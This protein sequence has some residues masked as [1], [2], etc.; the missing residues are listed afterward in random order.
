MAFLKYQ[1]AASF[2]SRE[3]YSLFESDPIK[4][5]VY[6]LFNS[7][8]DLA[9][10]TH[11]VS[12]WTLETCLHSLWGEES[13]GG[14]PFKTSSSR[15]TA[16]SLDFEEF[17]LKLWHFC[18]FLHVAMSFLLPPLM[19]EDGA[20]LL[21]HTHFLVAFGNFPGPTVYSTEVFSINL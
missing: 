3:Q 4:C 1:P 12:W 6:L 11:T 21:W 5:F 2:L 10:F 13:C 18:G 8:V 19:R 7:R 9:V 15:C 16:A 20:A 17:C 14:S